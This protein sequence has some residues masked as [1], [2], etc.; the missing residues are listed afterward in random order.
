MMHE[1]KYETNTGLVVSHQAKYLPTNHRQISFTLY[2]TQQL[3][4]KNYQNKL[5]DPSYKNI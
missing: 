4:K 2:Y 3:Q 5:V 1:D